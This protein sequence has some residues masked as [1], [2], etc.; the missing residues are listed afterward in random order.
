M[1][2]IEI[3]SLVVVSS[4]LH[5]RT[6]YPEAVTQYIKRKHLCRSLF[7]NKVADLRSATLLERDSEKTVF[8]MNF[9]KLLRTCFVIEE[10]R[11]LLDNKFS[12]TKHCTKIKISINDFFSTCDKIGSFLWIWSHL[13]TKILT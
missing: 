11:L 10:E 8:S 9:V 2:F 12:H 5:T 4:V 13:L 3:V 7:F 1:R 6:Y